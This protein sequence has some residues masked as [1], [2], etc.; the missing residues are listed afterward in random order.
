M[1]NSTLRNLQSN[2]ENHPQQVIEKIKQ[3]PPENITYLE[4]TMHSLSMLVV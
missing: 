1:R 4:Y 2:K 3:K